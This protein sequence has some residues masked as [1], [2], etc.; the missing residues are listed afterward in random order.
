MTRTT[1]SIAARS[2]RLARDGAKELEAS[3]SLAWATALVI[4]NLRA[5]RPRK[6]T[7]RAASGQGAARHRKSEERR[8]SVGRARRAVM[9][10]A[11]SQDLQDQP[12]QKVES[13]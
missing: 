11:T 2:R 4:A 9:V 8:L 12:L 7:G 6:R 5:A 1:A 10:I 13:P 3:P